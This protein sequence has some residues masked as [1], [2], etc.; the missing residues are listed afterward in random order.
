MKVFVTFFDPNE[1]I[2][3]EI[4]FIPEKG[5]KIFFSEDDRGKL[6]DILK[7]NAEK[8]DMFTK[9]PEDE[10]DATIYSFVDGSIIGFVDLIWDYED[11]KYV[12]IIGLDVDQDPEPIDYDDSDD[13]IIDFTTI[14]KQN[15]E[16]S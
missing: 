14:K 9:L 1:S 11:K 5:S 6:H 8:I 4:P 10:K 15:N 2:S 16:L 3:I 7:K 12:P 13:K